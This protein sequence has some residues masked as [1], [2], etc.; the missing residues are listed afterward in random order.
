MKPVGAQD[1]NPSPSLASNL[2]ITLLQALSPLISILKSTK[3]DKWKFFFYT[4]GAQTQSVVKA[5]L[6]WLGA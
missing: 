5:G 1:L 4:L 6:K 3:L 2:G